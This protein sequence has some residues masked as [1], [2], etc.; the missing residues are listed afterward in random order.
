MFAIAQW[1]RAGSPQ[2]VNESEETEFGCCDY[3]TRVTTSIALL[4][5]TPLRPPNAPVLNTRCGWFGLYTEVRL[6]CYR[7][8][9]VQVA[10][11]YM[12]RVTCHTPSFV[13]VGVCLY[14]VLY[15]G[16]WNGVC[17]AVACGLCVRDHACPCTALT[18]TP[19]FSN[20]PLLD[21]VQSSHLSAAYS[22][23]CSTT[24]TNK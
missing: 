9:P 23:F 5:N 18:T 17:C 15:D 4:G 1:K 22:V 13:C 21:L 11:P 3:C 14:C 12:S 2:P 20:T 24:T 7:C 8:T 6:Y 16:C 10:T 19:P